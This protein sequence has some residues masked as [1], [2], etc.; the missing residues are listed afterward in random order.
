MP[1]RLMSQ[2]EESLLE[3]ER[4][5]LSALHA[6]FQELQSG[7]D[8]E[9][10]A[11]LHTLET[12]IEQLEELFLLV[13]V[14]EFNTGKSALINAL[15]GHSFVEEGVIPTTTQIYLLKYGETTE[16][17]TPSRAFTTLA[18]PVD[19]LREINVVD[20]PGTNTILH[21]HQ[22]I[23][24]QFIPRSDLVLFVTS[25]DRPFSE[26]ERAFMEQIRNWG[27]K[28]VIA[29]NKIDN[30]TGE[31]QIEE[32]TD[33]VRQNSKHLLGIIPQIFPV[34]ARHAAKAK[35]SD[36]GPERERLWKESRLEPLERYIFD[37]LDER[38]RIRLKLESP[39]G[40][41]QRLT[42]QGLSQCQNHLRVLQSDLINLDAIEETL[43]SHEAEMRRDFEAQ[44]ARIDRILL[45]MSQRGTDFFDETV[46]LGRIVD[47]VNSERIRGE[48]ER[49]VVGDTPRAVEQQIGTV[50]DWLVEQNFHQWER[51]TEY[52]DRRRIV[53][54]EEQGRI[55]GEV[56]SGFEYNRQKLLESVGKTAR[57]T[58]SSYDREKE[59]KTLAESVRSAVAQTALVEVGAVGLGAIL[60]KVLAT[61]VADVSGLLAAGAVAALGLYILPARRKRAKSDLRAKVDGLRHT[62]ESALRDDFE[63]ELR[64]ALARMKQNLAPYTRFVRNEHDK[65]TTLET[66]FRAAQQ[67]WERLW[68]EVSSI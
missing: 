19:W 55:V 63:E 40:V 17:P 16:S 64:R 6:L 33:Y 56:G 50:I 18:F 22:A 1:R 51:I 7:D 39:L 36:H 37:T 54:S 27:K 49:Q 53:D 65:L 24:E 61:A 34:S 4:N 59:A 30:L 52:L 12:S 32:I 8:Q 9:I 45:Q 43:Q 28:V 15:L 67:V 44:L 68:S 31:T 42:E 21:Q 62:L 13:V 46:R 38:A 20:T 5:H 2:K 14:G 41:A 57:E 48:F 58:M 29:I 3:Q 35:G 60:T 10:S 26:S 11:A 47:L 23:T 25:A 66:E